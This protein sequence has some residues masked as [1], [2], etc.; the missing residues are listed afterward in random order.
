M[1]LAIVL[2]SAADISD[3]FAGNGS[4]DAEVER[5]LSYAQQL[6]DILGD[7]AHAESVARV[8]IESV[9]KRSTVDRDDVSIVQHGME[10]ALHRDWGNS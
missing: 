5:L 2:H 8:A 6:S 9:E 4:L 1:L 3:M 10:T 7:L